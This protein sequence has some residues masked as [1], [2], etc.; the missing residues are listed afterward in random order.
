M[1]ETWLRGEP[2]RAT[3]TIMSDL[4]GRA[5]EGPAVTGVVA[6]DDGIAH[7]WVRGNDGKLYAAYR[8]DVE[9]L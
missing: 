2:V 9:A 4:H 8:D 6:D 3:K 5:H 7:I 1:S